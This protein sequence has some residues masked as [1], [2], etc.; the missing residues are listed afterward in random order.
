MKLMY[1]ITM[2]LALVLLPLI[3][4]WAGLFYFKTLDEVNDET[5]DALD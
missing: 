3:A 4:V 2:R 1:R 5:D